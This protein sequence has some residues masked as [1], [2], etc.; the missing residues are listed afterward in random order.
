MSI[1]FFE[2][3]ETVGTE[4][5][6]ANEATSRPR[7]HLR[8]DD[9]S[10]GLTPSTDSYFLIADGFGEG[11]A[12]N[13]GTNG[14]F[15]SQNDLQWFVP[16]AQR[17][18]PG[19]S[20]TP[21]IIGLRVHVPSNARTWNPI[22][23]QGLY[24]VT[25]QTGVLSLEIEDSANI[26]INRGSPGAFEIANADGVLNPGAWH[27]IEMEF[28]IADSGDGGYIEVRLDGNEV[29]AN[30]VADTNNDLS[31]GFAELW[32]EN[33][34]INTSDSGDYVGY[35][36][37][38]IINTG[39]SPHTDFLGPVRV[40]SLPPNGDALSDWDSNPS[41]GTNYERVDENGADSSDYVETDV[42]DD[43][44]R[45][46]ITNT[47]ESDD[48]VAVKVEAEAINQT[49]GSPSLHLEVVSGTAMEPTE[50]AVTTT[51]DYALFD[52]YVQNDPNGGGAWTT[53][54]IDA[55]QVGYRFDNN[56]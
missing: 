42:K 51:T 4:I 33:A 21:W 36:D 11:Y 26:N 16:E 9:T 38:Y 27:Y 15:S 44:D 41:G 48:V 49:G 30:T 50:F 17:E 46:N 34:S 55:M 24:G 14:G 23:I 7:I 35:D 19:A 12:I 13:M 6:L 29:I 37:I 2:G 5:G 10:S 25:N 54:A 40:R 28:K 3:F 32:I 43:R 1:E 39:N 22:F 45:Y 18:A 53:T 31:T 8:W 47:T 20:F 56:L 52:V